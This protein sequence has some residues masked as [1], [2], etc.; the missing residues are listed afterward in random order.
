M[1]GDW[2]SISEMPEVEDGAYLEAMF[3][4]EECGSYAVLASL[5]RDHAHRFRKCKDLE[6]VARFHELE[7]RAEAALRYEAMH[8]FRSLMKWDHPINAQW[9][10]KGI[11]QLAKAD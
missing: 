5:I 4:A 6:M 2:V 10:N 8:G 3:S 7:I 1:S 11:I 9:V